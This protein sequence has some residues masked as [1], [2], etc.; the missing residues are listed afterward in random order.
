MGVT[1]GTGINFF[2]LNSK[3]LFNKYFIA[4][5]AP[6]PT[7]ADSANQKTVDTLQEMK[8]VILLMDQSD[9]DVIKALAGVNAAIAYFGKMKKSKYSIFSNIRSLFHS[10][11]NDRLVSDIFITSKV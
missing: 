10:Y 3:F 11:D 2:F 6:A 5:T 1:P 8:D 4:S 7:A 9:P